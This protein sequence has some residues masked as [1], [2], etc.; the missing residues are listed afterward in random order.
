MRQ[1]VARFCYSGVDYGVLMAGLAD[2]QFDTKKYLLFQRARTVTKQDI[3]QGHDCVHVTLNGGFASSY[4]GIESISLFAK[5]LQVIFDQDA[6]SALGVPR[7]FSVEFDSCLEGLDEFCV[8]LKEMFESF[9]DQRS[10]G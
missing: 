9:F 2:D 7:H 8:M 3:E 1:F 4:G 5:E 10:A 6:A